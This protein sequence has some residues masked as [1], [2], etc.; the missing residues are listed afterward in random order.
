MIKGY[1]LIVIMSI[2]LLCGCSEE[3]IKENTIA[4]E[5]LDNTAVDSAIKTNKKESYKLPFKIKTIES[6]IIDL[7]DPAIDPPLKGV[8]Y[9]VSLFSNEKISP[10]NYSSYELEI[11][12]NSTLKESLGPIQSLINLTK[13]LSD[14]YLYSIA[15]ETI[16]RNYSQEELENL[17]NDRDFRVFL[18]YEEVRYPVEFQ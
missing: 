10:E 12:A 17:K 7:N 16:Y 1:I 2:L 11:A 15:F 5:N 9:E 8:R 4:R 6:K 13:T 18:N 14:G 3:S